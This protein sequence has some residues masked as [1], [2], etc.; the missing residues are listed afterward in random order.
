MMRMNL[1]R[2]QNHHSLPQRSKSSNYCCELELAS[3]TG[4]AQAQGRHD[5]LF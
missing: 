2:S 3:E 5:K 4:L 1:A